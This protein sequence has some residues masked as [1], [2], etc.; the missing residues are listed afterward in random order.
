MKPNPRIILLILSIC[1]L[2]LGSLVAPGSS[3]QQKTY[4]MKNVG[5]KMNQCT[6]TQRLER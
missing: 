2:A 1:L 5:G 6:C 3:R 4:E